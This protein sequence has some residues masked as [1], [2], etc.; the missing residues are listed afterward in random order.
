MYAERL[1]P[2]ECIGIISLCHVGDPA[3]YERINAVLTRL[4][5]TTKPGENL[6]KATY[7]YEAS[8]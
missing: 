1:K 6:F 2:G 4:G 8:I 7:G 5:F 3:N